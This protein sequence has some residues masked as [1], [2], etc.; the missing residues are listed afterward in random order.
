M[1]NVMVASEGRPPS[2]SQTDHDWI[3]W[4]LCF[5]TA[6][7]IQSRTLVYTFESCGLWCYHRP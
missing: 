1:M 7:R 6:Q 3:L 5:S 2:L 4:I